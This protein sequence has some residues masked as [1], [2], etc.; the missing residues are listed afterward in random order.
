MIERFTF[1]ERLVHWT[2]VILFVYLALTGLAFWSP[3]MYWLAAV[4]GGGE[5]IRAWH[6]WVGVAFSI[7]L[8]LMFF[9]WARTMLLDRDDRRWLLQAHKYAIHDTESLPEAGRFNAGQKSMFWIQSVA[10]LLL[11]ISGLILWWPETV[12]R[13]WRLIAVVL[14]PSAAVISIAGVLIHIYMATAATPGSLSSMIRG[15]VDPN[16]AKS[17]HPK[18]HRENKGVRTH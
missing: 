3:Q 8:L 4:F 16:W 15:T 1:Y 6:P 9:N 17:H 12:A 7:A 13:N 5:S 11:L 18:W 2:V 14:H 10:A